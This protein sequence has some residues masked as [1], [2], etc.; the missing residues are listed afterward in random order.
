[1]TVLLRVKHLKKYFGNR[2]FGKSK[3]IRAVEDV[4]FDVYNNE[5]L[6]IV[7]ESGCGKTTTGRCILRLEEPTEG[8]IIF[9]NKDLMQLSKRELRPLRKDIQIVF[10]DPYDSLNPRATVK[11]ILEEPLIAHKVKRSEHNELIKDIMQKVGLSPKQMNKYPHQFS[12][13]QRQRI[14]I[15]RALILHPKLIVADEPVSALD[16]SIQSQVLNL[17][18]DL[19]EGFNLSYIFIS[20]D[21]SVVKYISNRIIVMYLGKVVEECGT[22]E[23]FN[24]PLH[25]YTKALISAILVPNPEK[26]KKK[27]LIRGELPSAS[28]QLKGCPFHTRCPYKF[29]KCYEIAPLMKKNNDHHYVA[30]HLY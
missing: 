28:G 16:V 8:K 9:E 20:H 21:L 18:K 15:A 23:L 10:Q 5:T 26:R 29:D 2:K 12:G 24:N 11:N 6:A 13:G 19:Q 22:A 7:G 3:I 25:P 27:L 4:S 17:M 1:M 14:G 30:C